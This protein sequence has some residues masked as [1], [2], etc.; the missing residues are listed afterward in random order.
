[1]GGGDR[2]RQQP[3]RADRGEATQP[4]SWENYPRPEVALMPL[5]RRDPMLPPREAFLLYRYY[6]QLETVLRDMI[7]LEFKAADGDNWADRIAAV[8]PRDHAEDRRGHDHELAYL[9]TPHTGPVTYLLF[10][11]VWNLI[12]H[13]DNWRLF[14]SYFL[15]KDILRAK[16]NEFVLRVRNRT[17]HFRIPHEDDVVRVRQFL[18][19]IDSG[20][21]QFL[22]SYN[23]RIHELDNDPVGIALRDAHIVRHRSDSWPTVLRKSSRLWAGSLPGIDAVGPGILYDVGFISRDREGL[24]Y[25][26]ILQ[27]TRQLHQ[28]VAFVHYDGLELR[29]T[30]PSVLG[31]ELVTEL[32]TAF[33]QS[34]LG[35]RSSTCDRAE[36]RAT[37]DA[38]ADQWPEYVLNSS[39]PLTF[40]TPSMPCP[41]FQLDPETEAR[42]LT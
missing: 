28:H 32:V 4:E 1:M 20:I 21:W 30:I 16:L 15:R 23:A 35:H 33:R 26:G 9:E 19:D 5:E 38:V 2:A 3:G 6:W 24:D 22:T 25:N 41:I 14:E 13:D 39:H 31:V 36:E 40:L 29:F 8:D 37:A 11:Q 27:S 18:R 42:S 34:A 10:D 17:A 7:Y 12:L